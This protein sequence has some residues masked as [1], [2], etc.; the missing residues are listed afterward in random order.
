[1]GAVR[2]KA[3][4]RVWIEGLIVVKAEAIAQPC[5]DIGNVA[6]EVAAWLEREQRGSRPVQSVFEDDLNAPPPGCPDSEVGAAPGRKLGPNGEASTRGDLV[7]VAV[8]R[9]GNGSPRR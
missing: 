1:M 4:G 6:G 5:A 2:L 8:S 3:R 9:Y 7:D